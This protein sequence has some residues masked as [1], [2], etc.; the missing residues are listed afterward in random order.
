VVVALAALVP[1]PTVPPG[2]GNKA[3]KAYKPEPKGVEE[4]AKSDVETGLSD[5]HLDAATI[6]RHDD[7]DGAAVLTFRIERHGAPRVRST[8]DRARDVRAV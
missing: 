1:R 3:E 4:G 5:R 6:A 8:T 2:A 7:G